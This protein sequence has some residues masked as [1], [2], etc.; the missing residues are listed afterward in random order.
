MVLQREI[1]R[2]LHR[3]HERRQLALLL[4]CQLETPA[5]QC[6]QLIDLRRHAALIGGLATQLASQ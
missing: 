6:E 5:L 1:A 2:A 4:G 3:R